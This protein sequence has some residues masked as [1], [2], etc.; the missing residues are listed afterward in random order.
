MAVRCRLRTEAPSRTPKTPSSGWV[1][2]SGLRKEWRKLADWRVEHSRRMTLL[3]TVFAGGVNGDFRGE[4]GTQSALKGMTGIEND[5][6]WIRCHDLSE[7][8][9]RVVREAEDEL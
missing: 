2:M 5:L 9:G 7:V 6:Y 1:V 8:S 3:R 4:A